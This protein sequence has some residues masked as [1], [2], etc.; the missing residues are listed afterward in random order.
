MTEE[1]AP[2]R[3]RRIA[4]L[5]WLVPLWLVVSACLGIWYHLHQEKVEAEKDTPRFATAIS[6]PGLQG[7]VAKFIDFVGERHPGRP[8]GLNRAAAMIEGSLGPSNAGYKV[9]RLRGPA[10]GGNRW[11]ILIVSLRGKDEDLPPLWVVAAYDSRPGSPGVEANASG[12]TSVLAA[13]SA[14]ATGKPKRTVN[15]AFLPHACDPESPLMETFA[16]LHKRVGKASEVLVVEATGA[17]AKLLLSSRDARSRALRSAEGL[18]EV[19]GAESICLEDDFDLSSVLF[20]TGLPAVRVSTRS[21]VTAAEPDSSAPDP[22]IHAAATT[23]LLTLI[24][25]LS[26]S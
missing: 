9:E 5:L 17:K 15:F 20:E 4:L 12:T 25:R 14:L 10:A 6:V 13:A 19:V 23:A 3:D 22:A 7:D 1:P 24:G 16:I 8:E 18:G 11:P 2:R 21:V 26:D